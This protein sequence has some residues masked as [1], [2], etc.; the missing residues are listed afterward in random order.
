MDEMF[1]QV[2]FRI[3]S[4]S[5][6]DTV[7]STWVMMAIIAL[8]AWLLGRRRPVAL[9]MLVE[10]LA[11]IVSDMMGRPAA[12]YLS[13]LGTL[14]I[15]IAVAN[16]IGVVPMMSTPTK[17]INTPIALALVV[18]FS[19]HYF[20][21]H[22]LGLRGYIKQLASPVFMLPLE[23]ISQVSRTLSLSLRL[24]GNIISGEMIVGVIFSLVP[25]IAPLPLQIFTMFT[26]L[27]QAYI[28]T[29]LATVYVGAAVETNRN[30]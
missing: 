11:G 19:V 2:V 27:L 14:C 4:V 20:G 8:V 10:F 1:P 13:L 26:G 6:Y 21:I 9:E 25:L 7:S 3:G 22:E 12:P 24:F 30:P 18:F 29:V 15:F 28:F 23:A 5:I 17:D 16:M